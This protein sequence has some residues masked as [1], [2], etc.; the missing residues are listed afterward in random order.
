[1]DKFRLGDLGT[2]KQCK[3]KMWQ[4][5]YDSAVAVFNRYVFSGGKN[6]HLNAWR[7]KSMHFIAAGYADFRMGKSGYPISKELK[8]QIKTKEGRKNA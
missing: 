4:N 5:Y 2:F 3:A 6:K 7:E 8:H 1:M